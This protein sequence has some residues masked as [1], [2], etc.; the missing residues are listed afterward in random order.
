M[1][2]DQASRGSPVAKRR[3]QFGLFSSTNTQHTFGSPSFGSSPTPSPT[4]TTP[5]RHASVKKAT[6]HV[7][8]V[9]KPSFARSRPQV[10]QHDFITPSDPASKI[11]RV[12]SV[13]GF[14][15]RRGSISRGTSLPNASIHPHLGSNIGPPAAGHYPHPLSQ[16]Q[17]SFGPQGS[18]YGL[19]GSSS[20]SSEEWRT[21]QNFRFA[22]PNPAAFH[23]TGFVP[24]RGRLMH[25]DKDHG[26]QPDT[27]CKRPNNVF[28]SVFRSQNGA[29]MSMGEL[30]HNSTSF[31]SNGG[32]V[33]LGFGMLDRRAST[34]SIDDELD[35]GQSQSSAD[36]DLPP[37]PTKKAYSIGGLF[38]SSKR[39]R[40]E[41]SCKRYSLTFRMD[42]C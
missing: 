15:P 1:N 33:K 17:N 23:S 24:K 31:G 37:T 30:G 5:K 27:P 14:H 16:S 34:L 40:N 25:A 4:S 19:A 26:H 6:G 11:R 38:N 3:S 13:D 10:R 42:A 2:L 20:K 18:D 9:E 32:G 22:K 12:T 8:G 7:L 39:V 28:S 41:E 36:Y 21:P 35:L 29:R